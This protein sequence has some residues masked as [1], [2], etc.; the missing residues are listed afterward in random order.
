MA[1]PKNHTIKTPK[2]ENS[3]IFLTPLQLLHFQEI[4]LN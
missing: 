1:N 2:Q 4:P 3:L